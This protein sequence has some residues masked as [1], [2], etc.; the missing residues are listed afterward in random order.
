[1]ALKR[2]DISPYLAWD[3]HVREPSLIKL[4]GD[5]SRSLRDDG[6]ILVVDPRYTEKNSNRNFLSTM[7]N[8][9]ANVL[10]DQLQHRI[11]FQIPKVLTEEECEELPVEYLPTIAHAHAEEVVNLHYAWRIGEGPRN[12]QDPPVGF[13]HTLDSFGQ[14]LLN[15][16]QVVAEMVAI[17]FGIPKNAFTS[18]IHM[19][20]HVLAPSG[21]D[22]SRFGH[23][24]TVLA[25]YHYDF[26]FLTI[27]A[28][29]RFPGLN[30]W[31]ENGRKVEVTIPTGCLL[32]QT[33]KQ[34][35]WVTGGLCKAGMSEVV[36]DSRT[37]NA[38]NVANGQKRNL[39]GISSMLYVQ[40]ALDVLLKPLKFFVGSELCSD[41]PPVRAGEYIQQQLAGGINGDV[42]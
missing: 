42:A 29:S 27:Q 2:F 28:K 11:E 37:L 4:C 7:E 3:H 5:M 24:G 13:R 34:I 36:V 33:G 35:E 41:Y 32:I 14:T 18:L 17:G 26:N 9:F 22:L 15:T 39:W 20:P 25:P 30:V 23:R 19:G 12:L 6:A 38:I 10:E 21:C 16:A 40:I 31:L 1:M 8:F